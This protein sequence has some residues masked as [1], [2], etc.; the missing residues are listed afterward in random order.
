MEE[1][2]RHLSD[3]AKGH[4]RHFWEIAAVRVVVL[5]S[6]LLIWEHF[7]Y[8]NQVYL[9]K[10]LQ[11][12]AAYSLITRIVTDVEDTPGYM[13]GITPVAISGYF[14]GSLCLTELWGFE[15]VTA[16]AMGKTSLTYQGTDYSMLTY[17]LSTNMNLT[18]VDS[19]ADAIRQMP[20]YPAKGSI[21]MV[22]GVLV[23]KVSD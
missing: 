15:D 13:P 20:V 11:E 17:Y 10:S 8:A 16:Y 3:E 5:L 14:E 6:G 22:D 2:R 4:I 23:I 1:N 12:K 18:R 21:S 7:I 9:K 19:S